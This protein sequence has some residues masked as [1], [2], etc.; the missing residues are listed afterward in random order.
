[1]NVWS[2]MA[3]ARREHY[4]ARD[5]SHGGPSVRWIAVCCTTLLVACA[6]SPSTN[7]PPPAPKRTDAQKKLEAQV[8]EQ[9][10]LQCASQ[11]MAALLTRVNN[12]T[13]YK[14]VSPDDPAYKAQTPPN[15]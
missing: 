12:A 2:F 6:S 10:T 13:V 3:P 15:P 8:L 9:A 4:T 5:H 11:G 1:M 14:C 7:S